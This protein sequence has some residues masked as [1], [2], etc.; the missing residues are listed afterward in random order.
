MRFTGEVFSVLLETLYAA[1]NNLSLRDLFK[2][3]MV[4]LLFLFDFNNS[5]F[6]FF[7][8]L[9]SL[10]ISFDI[11]LFGDSTVSSQINFVISVAVSGFCLTCVQMKFT[12]SKDCLS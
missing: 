5:S 4:F 1:D 10:N 11:L 8:A 7:I 2:A 9:C 3:S 12:L 6:A